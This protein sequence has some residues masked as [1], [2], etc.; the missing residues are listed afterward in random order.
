MATS[1]ASVPLI[2]VST[3]GALRFL[4]LRPPANTIPPAPA[5]KVLAIIWGTC[6][7]KA[8]VLP[9][10]KPSHPNQSNIVPKT[11]NCRL[12]L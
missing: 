4:Q 10:L 1:P 7:L 12:E 2:K 9:P 5:S 6:S 11:E 3:S 8:R